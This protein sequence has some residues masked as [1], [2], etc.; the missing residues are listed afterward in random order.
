MFNIYFQQCNGYVLNV[1]KYV[2]VSGFVP[3]AEA[4]VILDDCMIQEQFIFDSKVKVVTILWFEL[5]KLK[6]YALS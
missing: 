1:N 6:S 2:Q 3:W 5:M 4:R